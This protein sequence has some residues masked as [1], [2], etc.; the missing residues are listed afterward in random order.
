MWTLLHLRYQ[1]HIFAG[2]GEPGG[3]QG[4]FG[5]TVKM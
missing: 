4:S 2:H 5:L 3:A 1:K